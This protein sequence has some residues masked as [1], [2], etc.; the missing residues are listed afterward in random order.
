MFCIFSGFGCAT[1]RTAVRN[2]ND[3]SVVQSPPA[4]HNLVG[5]EVHFELPALAILAAELVLQLGDALPEE[6]LLVGHPAPPIHLR[7]AIE[8][9][10]HAGRLCRRRPHLR[11]RLRR[12]LRPVDDQARLD[13]AERGELAHLLHQAL[14]PLL[15][16]DS[17]EN[18]IS[19]S[20]AASSPPFVPSASF[21]STLQSTLIQIKRVASLIS[22]IPSIFGDRRLS[23]AITDCLELLD[24]S[25]DE[26]SW[27]LSS[28]TSSPVSA[29]GGGIGDRRFD[30]RSWMS[31]A[32]G[33]Q[34]TCKEGLSGKFHASVIDDGLDTITPSS[35]TP[36]EKSS[37]PQVAPAAGD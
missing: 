6:A 21:W 30:L 20:G 26:L 2:F 36:S 31:T 25:S 33:N 8:A 3:V 11:L 9:H 22:R 15:E 5:E 16:G 13:A 18:D 1:T 35:P 4:G 37:A 10:G 29:P 27:T 14:L 19:D 7:H 32:L 28:S 12:I 23:A 17:S 34:D 24:L